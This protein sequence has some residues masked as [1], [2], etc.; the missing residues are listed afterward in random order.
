M[1]QDWFVCQV[2]RSDQVRQFGTTKGAD[3]PTFSQMNLEK[4]AMFI[5][6]FA[7]RVYR[8]DYAGTFCPATAYPTR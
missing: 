7:K 2:T 5:A 1:L 8:L 6:Y 4:S 3:F